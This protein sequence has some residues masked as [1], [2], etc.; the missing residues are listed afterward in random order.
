MPK[1]DNN[2]MNNQS[3]PSTSNRS[4]LGDLRRSKMSCSSKLEDF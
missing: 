1:S 2:R 4:G 3:S